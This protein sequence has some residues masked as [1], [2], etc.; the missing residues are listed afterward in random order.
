ML[1]LVL[2][3][4]QLQ[5]TIPTLRYS[6]R[7]T[8]NLPL[9]NSPSFFLTLLVFYLLVTFVTSIVRPNKFF[10][11]VKTEVIMKPVLIQ[12]CWL[13]LFLAVLR[14]QLVKARFAEY[15]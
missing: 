4:L 11:A 15:T 9:Q 14:V 1:R 5:R 12:R 13:E 6:Q 10:F 3:Q 8:I 2:G 7:R